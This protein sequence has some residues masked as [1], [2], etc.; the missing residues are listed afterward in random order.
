M[1]TLKVENQKLLQQLKVLSE[2]AQPVQINLNQNDKDNNYCDEPENH[3]LKSQTPYPHRMAHNGDRLSKMMQRNIDQHDDGGYQLGSQVLVQSTIDRPRNRK[4][5]T[6]PVNK[7]MQPND[8]REKSDTMNSRS[9]T[10]SERYDGRKYSERCSQSQK[11]SKY[12]KKNGQQS[13]KEQYDYNDSDQSSDEDS[14]NDRKHR[15]YNKKNV[16]SLEQ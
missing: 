6:V 15:R 12:D 3:S 14:G 11:Q 2:Q 8:S 16:K 5:P 7:Y 10:R 1:H 13:L 4:L 9:N